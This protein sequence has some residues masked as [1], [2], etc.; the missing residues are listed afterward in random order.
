MTD[1]EDQ[2]P[3]FDLIVSSRKKNF[4][5]RFGSGGKCS[6]HEDHFEGLN[7]TAFQERK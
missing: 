2:M 5:K 1:R 7:E 3:R 4:G 6:I